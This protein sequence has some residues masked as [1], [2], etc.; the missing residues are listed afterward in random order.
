MDRRP[1]FLLLAF[2]LLAA[3]PRAAEPALFHAAP[4]PAGARD[5]SSPEAAA[6]IQ[7]PALWQAIQQRLASGPVTL[8][9]AAGNYLLKGETMS[10]AAA[11][12]VAA[13]PPPPPPRPGEGGEEGPPP[14]PRP[15][16]GGGAWAL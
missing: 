3:A 16:E 6:G 9:L 4:D 8:R 12:S 14:P 7:D 15:N 13:G 11:E 2:V 1:L 10:A 5:G